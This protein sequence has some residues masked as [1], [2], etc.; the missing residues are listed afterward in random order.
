MKLMTI[1]INNLQ[2]NSDNFDTSHLH[3]EMFQIFDNR[4]D[5]EVRYLHPNWSHALDP[6]ATLEQVRI[7]INIT[8]Q[9]KNYTELQRIIYL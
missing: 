8:T 7:K 4:W 6:N 1:F 2:I 3:N 5:W 9:K